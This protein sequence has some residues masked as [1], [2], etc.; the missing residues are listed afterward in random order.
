VFVREL[1]AWHGSRVFGRGSLRS[2]V[3]TVDLKGI[4]DDPVSRRRAK[5]I[6]DSAGAVELCCHPGVP[7]ADVGKPGSHRRAAELDY[8]LSSR[9]RELL[10]LNGAR[11][12]SYWQ[13]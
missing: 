10:T 11:L 7:A 5:S 12:V 6:V 3:R 8:L 9:F 1:L 4:V 2:P 13:V